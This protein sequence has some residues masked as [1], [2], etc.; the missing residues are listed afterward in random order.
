MMYQMPPDTSEKEKIVGGLF[1]IY[2]VIQ[3]SA[4]TIAGII[5]GLIL[6]Y[7]TGI[8]IISVILLLPFVITGA[9]FALKKVDGLMLFT[10]LRLKHK[11]NKK[12]KYYVNSGIHNKMEFSADREE[13]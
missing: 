13:I 2:Q 6:Y 4:F 3:F 11:H 8:F 1:D 7:I 9:I 12:I 10:Y 5:I